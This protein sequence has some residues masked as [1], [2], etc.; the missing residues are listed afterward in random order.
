MNIVS[1][2]RRWM[3]YLRVLRGTLALVP[4]GGGR[5]WCSPARLVTVRRIASRKADALRACS[6]TTAEYSLV[7]D[8]TIGV[9][10]RCRI[11]GLDGGL[12]RID[13]TARVLDDTYARL[14]VDLGFGFVVTEPHWNLGILVQPM[15]PEQPVTNI[16]ISL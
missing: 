6:G 2:G 5:C 8:S 16:F 10:N 13:G 11:G 7:D 15:K 1:W 12:S 9:T 14:L 3:R 4:G